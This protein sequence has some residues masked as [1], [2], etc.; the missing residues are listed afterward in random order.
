MLNNPHALGSGRLIYLHGFRSSPA[1]FKAQWLLTRL[2]ELGRS[3][4]FACPQL[5]ASPREAVD[6][7]RHQFDLRPDDTLVGSSLGGY[8]AT[9]LAEHYG[10]RAVLLNPVIKAARDLRSYV[11]E[12]QMYHSEGSFKFRAEYLYEL[13][14]LEVA[15]ISFPQRYFLIAAKGDQS[16]DWNE[17]VAHYSGAGKL[18]LDGSDHGLSDFDDYGDQVLQFAGLLDA[19]SI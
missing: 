14:E 1:S 4:K 19:M 3:T 18:V 5:P 13:S 17:M 6:L 9:Y 12:H 16:L 7:V 11:G 10:C 2:T 8:F 15:M